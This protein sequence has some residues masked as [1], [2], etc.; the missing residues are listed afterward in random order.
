MSDEGVTIHDPAPLHSFGVRLVLEVAQLA[1]DK[2][3]P[4]E[5]ETFAAHLK[6]VF[7][8]WEMTARERVRNEARLDWRRTP[9]GMLK[10]VT[11]TAPRPDDFSRAKTEAHNP[12][13][14]LEEA[15]EADLE[16][17][18]TPVVRDPR[19]EPK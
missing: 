10:T 12:R 4:R 1:N 18:D 16:L 8:R 14:L 11:P 2:L 5:Q 13:K 3:T 7:A 19:E 6:G 15:R 9:S 17:R